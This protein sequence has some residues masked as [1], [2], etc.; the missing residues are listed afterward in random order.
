MPACSA[1]QHRASVTA[2]ESVGRP[3]AQ[4]P[5]LCRVEHIDQDLAEVLREL[6]A[7]RPPDAP[8][9]RGWLAV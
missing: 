9:V 8:P 5:V 7:R 6:E 2:V 4:S 1:Q 3:L